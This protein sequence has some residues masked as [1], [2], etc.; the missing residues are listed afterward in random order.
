M[1]C[2]CVMPPARRVRWAARAPR[3]CCWYAATASRPSPLPGPAASPGRH[4]FPAVGGQSRA[5]RLG[6]ETQHPGRG[7]WAWNRSRMILVHI[8]RPPGTLPLPPGSCYGI[9]KERQLLGKAIHIQTGLD[10]GLHVRNPVRQGKSD[11]LC[12]SRAGFTD[13]VA[14]DADRVPMRN[15]PWQKRN[16]SVI[17]RMDGAGGKI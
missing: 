1:I 7:F 4:C 14:R 6:V 17:R 15:L 3:P 11:F 10:G 8:R 12:G 16:T 9:E 13:V 5:G 2:W